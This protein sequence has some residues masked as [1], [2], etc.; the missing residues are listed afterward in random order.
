MIGKGARSYISQVGNIN[1]KPSSFVFCTNYGCREKTTVSLSPESWLSIRKIFAVKN[2][3]PARERQQIIDAVS[4]LE[5]IVGPITETEYDEPGTFPGFGKGNQLD[6]V[7][8]SLNTSTY[9]VMMEEDNLITEH[10]VL[11]P[12]Q[13][14]FMINFAWPHFAPVIEEKATGK[15]FVVD[16]WFYKNGAKPVIV[17]FQEWKNGWK[18]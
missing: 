3:D 1:P 15:W 2:S 11:G 12:T 7:A 9:L 18:P 14:G 4:L 10:N 5:T 16:S 17:S 6:C 8:E 13:R